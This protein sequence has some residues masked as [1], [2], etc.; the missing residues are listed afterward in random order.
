MALII[1]RWRLI[2]PEVVK[3]CLDFFSDK[4]STGFS[5]GSF[6]GFSSDLVSGL[7]EG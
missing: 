6:F 5:S 1:K 3:V 2:L 4:V 7:L